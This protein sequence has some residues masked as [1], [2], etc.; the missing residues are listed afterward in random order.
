M[1]RPT[2]AFRLNLSHLMLTKNTNN[3]LNLLISMHPLFM[4]CITAL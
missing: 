1:M 3:N 2:F 4:L